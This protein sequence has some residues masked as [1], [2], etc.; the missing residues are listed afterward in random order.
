MHET[1]SFASKEI[2]S[3]LKIQ[4]ARLRWFHSNV[5]Q[6]RVTRWRKIL[7]LRLVLRAVTS[8][9]EREWPLNGLFPHNQILTMS[10]L[11]N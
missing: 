1:L 8:S 11:A 10:N 3:S 2:G 9:E 7:S 4:A 6:S 5:V